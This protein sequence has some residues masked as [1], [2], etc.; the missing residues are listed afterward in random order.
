M[1]SI[2]PCTAKKYEILR[3]YDMFASGVQDV[4]VTITTREFARLLKQAGIDLVNLPEGQA[5]APLGIYS[6]AGLIFGATGGVMEAA[7]RTAYEFITDKEL[8][9]VDFESVRGFKGVKEAKVE[10]TEK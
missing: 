10:V 4:D 7:L 8:T 2:M 5:D 9:K 1:L 3:C 6:G